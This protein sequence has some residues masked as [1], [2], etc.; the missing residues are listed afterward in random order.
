MTSKE[1]SIIINGIPK[2]VTDVTTLRKALDALDARASEG[3]TIAGKVQTASSKTTKAMTEEEKA[4]KKLADTLARANRELTEEE[5]A[6]VSAT[7]ALRERNRE[8]QREVAQSEMA[9]DSM[10]VMGMQ[11][12][13]LRREYELLSEEERNNV[14]VGGELLTRIQELDKKYKELREST[15]NFRDSVG[16]YEKALN[17]IGKLQQ[18]L[19]TVSQTA[20]GLT[21]SFNGSNSSLNTFSFMAMNAEEVSSDLNK[22]LLASTVALQL[23]NALTAE[24]TVVTLAKA[25]ADKV[26]TIQLKAKTIAEGLSTKGTVLATIAQG[27]FNVVAYA[28]PYVLLAMALVALV[29]VLYTFVGST[30]DATDAQRALNEEQSIWLEYLDGEAGKLK[31]VS[32]ARIK[33]LERELELMKAKDS[34]LQDT[35]ALEDKILREKQLSN[36]KMRGIYS[37]EVANID[38]NVE[39]L[40]RYLDMLYSIKMAQAR[41]DSKMLVDIDL[42]GRAKTVKVEEA[43][44]IVQGRVDMLNRKIE[45]GVSL[46][47]EEAELEN[48][49]KIATELRKKEDK[50]KAVEA[51]AK[52]KE[53]KDRAIEQASK[54]LDT[55]R[56]LEDQKAKLLKN[57]IDAQ[58]ANVA[59]EYDRQIEDIKTRLKNEENLTKKAR[60]NLNGQ[61]IALEKV[62]AK[63]IE[64]INLETAEKELETSRLLE[65]LKLANL[66]GAEA[67]RRLEINYSYNRQI[68]DL[69]RRLAVEEDLTEK[70]QKDITDTITELQTRRNRELTEAS[71][72]A[73]DKRAKAE[74]N[75]YELALKEGLAK[76]GEVVKRD[77]KTGI[78]DAEAT[79]ENLA[80]VN[81]YYA[82]YIRGM[83]AFKDALKVSHE[84]TLATLKEGTPEY[85]EELQKYAHANIDAS[86]KIEDAQKTIKDNTKASAEAVKEEIAGIAG[87]VAKYAQL[88]SDAVS[89]V[90]D[91]L[92]AGLNAQ[93]EVLTEKLEEVNKHYEE[94]KQRREEYT[95]NVE[96]LEEK[97]QNAS[98]GTAEAYRAQLQDAMHL[99][100]ES[101]REEQ[102]LQREK[103]KREAEIAKKERQMRRN[104]LMGKIAMGIA[105]TA[106]AVTN[107]LATVMF[108]LNM[109]MAGVVGLAGGIQTGIMVNQ[110]TKMA[111][112]GE[113]SGATHANGGVR[114]HGTDIEVEGGEFV[115]NRGSYAQN[116][117][118]V[119]LINDSDA[120]V[121]VAQMLPYLGVNFASDSPEDD[122]LLEALS[123]I[124]IRPVVSVVDITD[125]QTQVTD[126]QDLAGF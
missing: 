61:I 57:T 74:A 52:A 48:A 53:A 47:T 13:D 99:R 11:L 60:E 4:K 117:A 70:Q 78:L 92:N 76:V 100:A 103:E 118:L 46:K 9:S 123:N 119:N 111:D 49:S 15:G 37:E 115:V 94:A 88:A 79:K 45:I 17:G 108:P 104:D 125:A 91:T 14:D 29:A 102:R 25:G 82:E 40:G 20:N 73:S 39:H 30:N 126:I 93:L 51:K 62:K 66:Q 36:A 59:K 105:N 81:K 110:L 84:N 124:N 56:Q 69:Q 19:N 107:M 28:N 112:G 33:M 68:E 95:A 96:A 44:D 21:S 75:A 7:R 31:I 114:V 89:A 35:R 32:D 80:E 64:K 22:A 122:P 16:N 65:D 38:T 63:E 83:I 90:V 3:V 77:Q 109:V 67:R 6:Q 54:E 87:E 2:A 41:G 72:E 71:I 1:Y 27:A 106:Q 97:L 98:G 18:G 58:R 113:I 86:K 120:P 55:A 50:A 85:E 10:A 121:S 42:N 8:I 23:A 34:K 12:T 43:L 116:K 101:E 26:A 5:R 24:G